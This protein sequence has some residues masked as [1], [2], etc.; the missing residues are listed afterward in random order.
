M[1][2]PTPAQEVVASAVPGEGEVHYLKITKRH[3]KAAAVNVQSDP[4]KEGREVAELHAVVAP[5]DD[6]P[7]QKEKE[8]AKRGRPKR[9]QQ[10]SP[11]EKV[12]EVLTDAQPDVP[13]ADNLDLSVVKDLVSEQQKLLAKPAAKPRARRA[14]VKFVEEA[15]A[16]EEQQQQQQQRQQSEEL[17]QVPQ[18]ED[19]IHYETSSLSVVS[20]ALDGMAI[21]WL[22]LRYLL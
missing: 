17:P 6:Q 9:V 13:A 22:L 18:D 3:R 14:S 11:D 15:K 5:D 12:P 20:Y 19:Y 4:P 2:T 10:E 8:K 7:I 1:Q 21:A 16:E